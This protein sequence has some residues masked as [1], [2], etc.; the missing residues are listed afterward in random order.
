MFFCWQQP[1]SKKTYQRKIEM[2]TMKNIPAMTNTQPLSWVWLNI[3]ALAFAL[4]HVFIDLH[5]GLFGETSV[6]MSPLQAANILFLVLINAWWIACLV[7]A[8]RDPEQTGIFNLAGAFTIV[9]VWAFLINGMVAV[10]AAPPPSAAF[11]YQD[12]T[13]FGSLIFGG[14]ASRAAWKEMKVRE[15][16]FKLKSALPTVLL[17]LFF[18]VINGALTIPIVQG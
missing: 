14:L 3:I 18:M 10:I 12:L 9:F 4:G 11:P 1:G 17:L 16:P 5:I 6:Y 8:A 7:S 15:I 13:H 2:Q